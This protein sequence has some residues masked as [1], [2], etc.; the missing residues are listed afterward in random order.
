GADGAI[1]P[2]R[3]FHAQ[4]Q[5]R[6]CGGGGEDVAGVLEA[7]AAGGAGEAV[8]GRQG[9]GG[10]ARAGRGGDRELTGGGVG[11]L[12]VGEEAAVAGH[13]QARVLDRGAGEDVG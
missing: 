12:C 13:A 10:V 1:G 6:L 11:Q 9:E 5:R 7:R 3:R 8:D 4:R 2:H